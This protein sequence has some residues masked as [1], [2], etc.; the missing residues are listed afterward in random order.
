MSKTCPFREA[1]IQK[2]CTIKVKPKK[3]ERGLP[4]SL[5]ALPYANAIV[6]YMQSKHFS[7]GFWIISDQF[8]RVDKI[9]GNKEEY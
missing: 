5:L 8:E 4:S 3:I 7:Q 6:A 9:F 1:K 2:L